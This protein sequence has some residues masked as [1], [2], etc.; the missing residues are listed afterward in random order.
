M[1]VILLFQYDS[2]QSDAIYLA[3]AMY[4]VDKPVRQAHVTLRQSMNGNCK[5]HTL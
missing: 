4:T 5:S 3:P 2:Y 1:F